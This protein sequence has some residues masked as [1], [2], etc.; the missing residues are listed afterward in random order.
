MRD[1]DQILL[2]QAYIDIEESSNVED[3]Y[4]F[5]CECGEKFKT[6]EAKK[7]CKNCSGKF[8]INEESDTLNENIS[9][10]EYTGGNND[11]IF[12]EDLL[13]N[14]P[15]LAKDN[16]KDNFLHT[17]VKIV[18]VALGDDLLEMGEHV[19]PSKMYLLPNPTDFT[20]TAI[21]KI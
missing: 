1:K 17:Q 2:E 14:N 20:H 4:P 5:E 9:Y 8:D 13:D 7:N 3:E 16:A 21:M 19:V 18:Y 10:K 15:R 6:E 11:L 12:L